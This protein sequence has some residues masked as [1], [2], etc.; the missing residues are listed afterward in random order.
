MRNLSDLY[1]RRLGP[2]LS[3]ET[4]PAFE[5]HFQVTLPPSYLHFLSLAN[6]GEP[7]L[8]CT[9]DYMTV[10]GKYMEDTDQVKWFGSLTDKQEDPQGIWRNT[11]L[12]RGVH[13]DL[14]RNTSVVW[15]GKTATDGMIYLDY[16]TSPVSVYALYR[17]CDETNPKVASSFEDF[18]KG[19]H[20]RR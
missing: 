15:L 7:M 13:S 16:A 2:A 3:R 11:V 6:G 5:K 17:E 12:L 10:F 8:D 4:V 1:L 9:F 14:G 19:L 18:V 20:Y